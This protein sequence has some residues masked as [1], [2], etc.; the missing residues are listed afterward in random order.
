MEI[1]WTGGYQEQHVQQKFGVM[2]TAYPKYQH[3]RV[4][5]GQTEPCS[6]EQGRGRGWRWRLIAGSQQLP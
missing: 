1:S 4:A 5:L 3:L 6:R 2:V